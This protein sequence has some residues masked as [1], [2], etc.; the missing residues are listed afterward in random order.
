MK[1]TE[2]VADI[3]EKILNYLQSRPVHQL[4][5][6]TYGNIQVAINEYSEDVLKAVQYLCNIKVLSVHYEFC[7]NDNDEYFPLSLDDVNDAQNLG[8][9]V[10]PE[11]GELI[12]DYK[13]KVLKYFRFDEINMKV[14]KNEKQLQRQNEVKDF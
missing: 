1:Q 10:H 2:R 9:L 12:Q 14:L 7:D 11:T 13:D 6:L 8:T 3:C 4:T 5:H